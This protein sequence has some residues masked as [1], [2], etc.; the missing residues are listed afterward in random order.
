MALETFKL[1]GSQSVRG[2]HLTQTDVQ[3]TLCVFVCIYI[4]R[5]LTKCKSVLCWHSSLERKC[6]VPVKPHPY[7]QIC[8]NT[9]LNNHLALSLSLSLSVITLSLCVCWR[10]WKINVSDLS[11]PSSIRI[12]LLWQSF[13]SAVWLQFNTEWIKKKGLTAFSL[14]FSHSGSPVGHDSTQIVIPP[15][16]LQLLK[17]FKFLLCWKYSSI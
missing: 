12:E 14:C 6:V 4:I 15:Q 8:S 13:S 11:F 17:S 3:T 9:H 7:L 10:I 16:R 2:F 5:P 1:Q